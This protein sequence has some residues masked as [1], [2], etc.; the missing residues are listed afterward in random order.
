VWGSSPCW[1]WLRFS[2]GAASLQ[3]RPSADTE[4]TQT[5][6]AF[7]GDLAASATASGQLLPQ[8]EAT[9]TVS[10]PAEVTAVAV[11]KGD[12]VT[13]GDL[14]VQLDNESLLLD[15]NAAAESLALSEARL[16]DLLAPPH[17]T[18]IATAEANVA[19]A[20]AQLADL[21]AGPTENEI[22]L[23]E[24]GV[25]S[26]T[27][28][29]Y[30]ASAD[31]GSASDTIQES[32][33]AAARAALLSA[34]LQLDAAVEAN[35]DN[36]TEATHEARLQAEQAVANAQA[37]LDDLLEGPSL[38]AAQGSVSAANARLAGSEA[39]LEQTLAGP[40]AAEVASAEASLAQAEAALANLLAGPTAAEIRSLEAEI[41]QARIN[42]TNAEEALADAAITAPFDGV[43][44]EVYVNKGEI[45][46]GA[47]VDIA[48]TNQ[49]DLVLDVD[50][51][52]IGNFT[53]GQP[54]TFSFEAY[55]DRLYD[56]E[57]VS[58][59]PS[60]SNGNNALVTY[61]VNSALQ[62][63][64]RAARL[65]RLDRQC[66]LDY[67]PARRCAAGAQCGHPARP[68]R[69]QILRRRGNGRRQLPGSGSHHWPAGW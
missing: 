9:L 29:L 22:A 10:T 37:Q 19:T 69:R 59:A 25:S 3:K 53:I 39:E 16:A 41:E 60:G 1:R 56:S 34:Q 38:G 68:R 36:P 48:D 26:A 8:R 24:I 11:R 49:L 40:T 12:T 17:E 28:S 45:A 46:T 64:R 47:V 65:A 42:L 27:A 54:A 4:S 66:Q 58:I 51:V 7:I 18:E 43:I 2:F 5:V 6:T 13:A 67:R 57:I 21:L 55:P 32:Q 14:L 50:E 35:E 63:G 23:A 44:T 30:A 15:V 62:R 31:L 52:D 20:Q 61:E 33:I